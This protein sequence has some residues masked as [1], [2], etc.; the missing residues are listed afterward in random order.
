MNRL[1]L[2]FSICL[3]A[4]PG[5]SQKINDSFQYD[6]RRATGPIRV[7]G[8][9]DEAAW[10]QTQLATDFRMVLPM[11]TSRAK[12]PTDVR[13]TYDE[14][15][16]Y[17]LAICY[18]PAGQPYVV[19][20]LRRDWNFG[21]NDNFILFIDTFDD[22]TNGF[23]FGVNAAG[24]QW[25]G[26]MY[27]GSRVNLS[28]DNKWT[29]TVK[30]YGDR[31]VFEAAIPFK[32]IRYKKGISRWGV[33]FSRQ[34]LTSTEK[35]SWAPIPRQFP[36]ATLAYT[37]TLVWDQPPPAA[38]ANVSIIPV[39]SLPI[40]ATRLSVLSLVGVLGWVFPFVMGRG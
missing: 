11:D 21:K 6:M 34:D 13:M 27:D 30:N 38:G 8:V 22:Q 31:Y 23:A 24:A 2:L 33:S 20:S 15:N 17:I 12:V 25:D 26:L 32:T 18:Y 4:L 9:A 5:L 36:T 1:L 14:Q 29:S 37:G 40:S 7:D 3:S 28:W 16:L 10:Q 35:S 39:I 19:E